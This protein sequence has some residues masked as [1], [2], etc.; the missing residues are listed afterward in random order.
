M[1]AAMNSQLLRQVDRQ[2][3]LAVVCLAVGW[4]FLATLVTTIRSVQQKYH[5]FYMMTVMLNPATLLNS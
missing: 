1:A 4:F 5:F 2:T 3:W